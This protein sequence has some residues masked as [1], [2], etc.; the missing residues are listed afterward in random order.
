MRALS[1]LGL[2]LFCGCRT[3]LLD[4]PLSSGE[5]A[6]LAPTSN[7]PGADLAS[8]PKSC[9]DATDEATCLLSAACKEVL[10]CGGDPSFE[11]CM[12][13]DAPL[14]GFGPFCVRTRCGQHKDA[15]S[16]DADDACHS[17]YLEVATKDC[18]PQ[19]PDCNMGFDHCA[20]GAPICAG[21]NAQPCIGNV[22]AVCT[23]DYV[24]EYDAKSGCIIDCVRASLCGGG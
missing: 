20:T 7:G 5:H 13:L 21:T 16:C 14:P 23:G 22:N 19:H 24:N 4:P 18:G 10:L 1:I 15:S 2:F 11:A 12:D 3:E 9:T 17:T 6:D 8:A